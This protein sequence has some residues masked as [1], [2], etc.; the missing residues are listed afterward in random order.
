M[1]DHPAEDTGADG[2]LFDA[3]I[4]FYIDHDLQ[5]INS[6][7]LFVQSTIEVGDIDRL[8]VLKPFYEIITDILDNVEDDYGELYAIA[9]E[10]NREAERLRELAQRIEDSG[11]SV[12]DLFDTAYRPTS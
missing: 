12:A 3:G 4:P 8:T 2:K 10:L 6:G 1:R 11:Q 9:N 5:V 7:T